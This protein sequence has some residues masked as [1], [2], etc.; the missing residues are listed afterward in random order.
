MFSNQLHSFFVIY[1]N[2]ANVNLNTV[3]KT[4]SETCTF[5][6]KSV[7]LREH[8]MTYHNFDYPHLYFEVVFLY[9]DNTFLRYSMHIL[10]FISR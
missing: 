1:N 9:V 5:C 8:M 7:I 4:N 2:Q 10:R 6:S 3:S